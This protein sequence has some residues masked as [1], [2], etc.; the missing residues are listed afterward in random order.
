[1]AGQV[2]KAAWPDLPSTQP[3]R[4]VDR[5]TEQKLSQHPGGVWVLL[6]HHLHCVPLLV[7]L[8]AHLV[9]VVV[10]LLVVVVCRGWW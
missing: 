1:M 7:G 10:C 2:P 8:V 6:R 9:V 4:R 3:L 5:T